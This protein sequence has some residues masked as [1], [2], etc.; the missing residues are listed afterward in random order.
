VFV[1]RIKITL[2]PKV[3]DPQGQTVMDSL[4]TLGFSHITG[5]R[6]GK[7][8]EVCVDEVDREKADQQIRTMCDQL[9]ANPIIEDFHYEMS[10][11]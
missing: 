1:A 5:V 4:K 7:Y 2:K 9:L 6:I 3:N 10:P 8:I 11:V